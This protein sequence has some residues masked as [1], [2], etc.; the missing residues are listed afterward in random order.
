MTHLLTLYFLDSGSYSKGF[1]DWFG[2]FTPTEY[3]YI[4]QSQIDWFLQESGAYIN[5][6]SSLRW[7]LI[8]ISQVQS[9]QLSDL[10]RLTPQRILAIYGNARARLFR[11]P[12]SSPNPM[13]WCSFIFLC[14][15]TNVTAFLHNSYQWLY[16][17]KS[18]TTKLTLTRA[19]VNDST[20]VCTT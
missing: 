16:L 4:H 6:E 15:L 19:P 9:M 13:R 17:V 18:L 1:I 7:S 5:N 12:A 2:F 8:S 14:K 10:S 20:S 11:P 3:D